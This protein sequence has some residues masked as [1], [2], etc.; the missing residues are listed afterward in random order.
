MGPAETLWQ[1]TDA[2]TLVPTGEAFAYRPRWPRSRLATPRMV[3]RLAPAPRRRDPRLV[4]RPSAA[5]LLRTLGRTVA[6]SARCRRHASPGRTDGHRSSAQA[7]EALEAADYAKAADLA[8]R[9]SASTRCSP[10]RTSSAARPEQPMGQDA[11][12]LQPLSRAVYLDQHAGRRLV[13]AR[14]LARAH[15]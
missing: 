15:R 5:A 6:R 3:D 13:P 4:A 10:R 12:A 14:G 7:R 11:E 9:P 2:F 8:E 1:L